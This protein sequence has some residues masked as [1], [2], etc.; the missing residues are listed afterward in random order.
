MYATKRWIAGYVV[1]VE[2]TCSIRTS[3][4]LAPYERR[5]VRRGSEKKSAKGASAGGNV[6]QSD[7]LRFLAPLEESKG[8]P[9]KPL[10]RRKT[11][12]RPGQMTRLIEESIE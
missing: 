4:E 6:V 10:R 9:P 2:G 7:Q 1:E 3:K 5:S 12:Q 11:M 8:V